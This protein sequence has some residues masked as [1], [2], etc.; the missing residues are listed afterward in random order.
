M[1]LETGETDDESLSV[2]L[3]PHGSPEPAD[4]FLA[5]RP[6]ADVEEDPNEMTPQDTGPTQ[7]MDETSNFRC[8]HPP[9]EWQT[10]HCLKMA[11]RTDEDLFCT[12][13][14]EDD[15]QEKW[16]LAHELFDEDSL[17]TDDEE[18][19]VTVTNKDGDDDKPLYKNAPITLAESMLLILTLCLRHNLTGSCLVDLLTLVSLHCQKPNLCKTS[20]YFFRQYFS[21]LSMPLKFH[22][23]CS[24]CGILID[25]NSKQCSSCKSHV[26]K[27]VRTSNFIEIPIVEQLKTFYKGKEFCDSLGYRFSR[28]KCSR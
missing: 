8:Q 5:S 26:Q 12:P 19:Q 28:K 3:P 15:E 1:Q 17:P 24:H 21:K 23:V 22:T 13:T 9:A 11:P 16:Y 20:L 25:A 14:E 7:S 2:P 10:R 18:V 27:Y 6:S 4:V